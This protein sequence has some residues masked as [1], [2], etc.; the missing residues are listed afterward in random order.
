MIIPITA[1]MSKYILNSFFNIL[2]RLSDLDANIGI[3]R[4]KSMLSIVETVKFMIKFLPISIT[5]S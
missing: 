1:L 5:E 2:S 3:H 4:K